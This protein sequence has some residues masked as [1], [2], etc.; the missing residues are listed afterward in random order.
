MAPPVGWRTVPSA[1]YSGS[2]PS[3]RLKIALRQRHVETAAALVAAPGR[4][5]P[6]QRGH[7]TKG[8]VDA[9]DTV[10][11]ADA[12]AY[13]R[14]LSGTRRVV[15]QV[16][17]ATHR[18]ADHAE[19]GAVALWPVL[20][21]AGDA[22]NH[23]TGVVRPQRRLRQAE[24][25]ELAGAEVFDQCITLCGEPQCQVPRPGLLQVER[26]AALVTPVHAPPG[27]LALVTR[28]PLPHRVAGAWRLHLDDISTK[29]AEQPRTEGRRDEVA[30][31]QDAQASQGACSIR[32]TPAR[33]SVHRCR[34]HDVCPLSRR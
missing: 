20:A 8:S 27:G 22:G 14:Q 11:D 25:V 26:D 1:P 32:S 33:G 19:G 3:S 6:P 4:I 34:C 28:A 24:L 16:A 29:V 10:A 23:Q 13:R 9:G 17:Q 18:F 30:E 15:G 7:D 5:A 21:V 31:L 2:A 12:D